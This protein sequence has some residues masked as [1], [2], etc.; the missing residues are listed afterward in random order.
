MRILVVEDNQALSA[1]VARWLAEHGYHPTVVHTG[2]R[3]LEHV[4][5]GGYDAVLLDVR[6]PGISG[7]ETCRR[8]REQ[9]FRGV[10]VMASAYGSKVDIDAGLEAGAD[11]Y[12]VKPFPLA[13]LDQRLRALCAAA[14]AREG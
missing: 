11:D 4:P 6:L 8:L 7:L 14:A 10:V 3:A 9:R 1:I 12:L 2:E 13:D 5:S